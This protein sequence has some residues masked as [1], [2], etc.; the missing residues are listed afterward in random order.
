MFFLHLKKLNFQ[1][2]FSFIIEYLANFSLTQKKFKNCEFSIFN[3]YK[4]LLLKY[5]KNCAIKKM[6][7]VCCLVKF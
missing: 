2:N 4:E 7:I 3:F 6:L 5:I 1:T